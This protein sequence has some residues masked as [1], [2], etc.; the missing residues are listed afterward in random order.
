MSSYLHLSILLTTLLY[1]YVPQAPENLQFPLSASLQSAP[2]LLGFT[3]ICEMLLIVMD[4]RFAELLKSR[5]V[6]E[7]A[8][9]PSPFLV[10]SA[11]FAHFAFVQC[12][13]LLNAIIGKSFFVHNEAYWVFSMWLLLY[14]VLLMFATIGAVFKLTKWYDAMANNRPSAS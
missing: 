14:G 2:P 6:E 5:D 11:S 3:L 10:A 4:K 12:A 9:V 7:P 13:G 8:G 1:L